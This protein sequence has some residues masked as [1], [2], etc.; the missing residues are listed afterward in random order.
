MDV[1]I[2][3]PLEVRDKGGPLPLGGF[4]QRALLAILATHANKVVPVDSLVQLI[5]ADDAP[6]TAGHSIHVYVS[7]LRK[8][9]EP[10]TSRRG[11]TASLISKPPGY[12]L[13]LE[14]EQ[15]DLNR[16]Q[17]LT[18]EATAS[19]AARDWKA[20]ADS[21]RKAL[22]VWRGPAFAEFTSLPFALRESARLNELR[23]RAM[24]NLFDCELAMG[25]HADVVAELESLL[26]EYPARERIAG[27]LMLALYRSGRQADASDVYQSTRTR[28]VDE[29]G[30]E[31]GSELQNLLKRILNH[32][33]SLALAASVMSSRGSHTPARI[34][35]FVGRGSELEEIDRLLSESRLVMLTGSGGVGKTR[36]A[37]EAG[38]RVADRYRDG[39]W[40]VDLAPLS[41]PGLV[42]PAIMAVFGL[43]DQPGRTAND[44]LAGY[45]EHRQILLIVDNCEHLISAVSSIASALLAACRELHV[46]ATSREILNVTGERIFRVPSLQIPPAESLRSAE[47][48]RRYQAIELFCDRALTAVPSFALTDTNAAAVANICRRLDGIPLAI[49]IAASRVRGLSV[50]DLSRRIAAGLTLV[51]GSASS[52]SRQATMRA[53]I[54]WSHN[55]LTEHE[56]VMF[57]RLSVFVGGIDLEAAEL[58]CGTHPIESA[59][60]VDLLTT[61]ADKS[62]IQIDP[63]AERTRY[64]ILETIR[65]YAHEKLTQSDDAESMRRRHRDWSLELA[66]ASEKQLHGD[67]QMLWLDR[68]ER[69]HQNIRAAS[70]RSLERN[71]SEP[72]VRLCAS[73]GPFWC[74]RGLFAEGRDRLQRALDAY[75]EPDRNRAQAV[76]WAGILARYQGDNEAAR[77]LGEESLELYEGLNDRL[78]KAHA[79]D[80]LAALDLAADDYD[81]AA[82]HATNSLSLYED[83]QC[84][85]GSAVSKYRL[86]LIRSSQGDS[87]AAHSLAQEALATSMATGDTRQIAY[88]HQLLGLVTLQ[89]GDT[90]TAKSQFERSLRLLEQMGDR[91]YVAI[92]LAYLGVASRVDHSYDSASKCLTEANQILRELGDE[93][94]RAF[95]LAELGALAFE[96]GEQISARRYLDDSLVISRE[97]DTKWVAVSAL[98]TVAAMLK[99]ET[100]GAAA[101]AKLL[102]AAAAIRES[103]AYPLEEF[104]RDAYDALMR[105]LRT[106]LGNAKLKAALA[107]GRLISFDDAIQLARDRLGAVPDASRAKLWLEEAAPVQDSTPP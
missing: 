45:F 36:L 63:R 74:A 78:G 40:V 101:A 92:S 55:L 10:R 54:D 24:E 75:T 53:M 72:Y 11:H 34:T 4:K 8:V 96:Q 30:M 16:F 94:D 70:D 12:M 5:W 59:A 27:Q 98:E 73:M 56:A 62:L 48:T 88:C 18:E 105:T 13:R 15:F 19:V 35:S 77:A 61:L 102:G 3:G 14:D 26:G 6:A 44:V 58:I 41:E 87:V 76:M 22:A 106:R 49:E 95:A 47:T 68:L 20:A 23:V 64:H 46:L 7:E 38:D 28:L 51:T 91:Y 31:P 42:G 21:Y 89:I 37:F 79:L 104:R 60:V 1:A 43:H 85:W 67:A 9:L 69:E 81:N 25:R 83:A 39:V 100:R 17:R 66:A 57:R 2:L 52:S 71:E 82:I 80:A 93:R 65:K 50:E 90:S 86:G 33:A 32:D 29:V 103:I 84:V 99:A 97:L 107:A